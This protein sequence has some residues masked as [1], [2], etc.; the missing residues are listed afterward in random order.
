MEKKVLAYVALFCLAVM[1]FYYLG[2]GV[3]YYFIYQPYAR[4]W[5]E[6]KS[7]LYDELTRSL[8]NP[9][10]LIW[11]ISPLA[12]LPFEIGLALLRAFTLVVVVYALFSLTPAKE[13]YARLWAFI[14]GLVNLHLFDLIFRGQIDAIALLGLLLALQGKSWAT[15]G[16]AYTLLAIKPPN[17]IPLIIYFFW[18]EWKE[19]GFRAAAKTLAIPAAVLAASLLLHGLWPLRWLESYRATSPME[20]W[21]TTLWRTTDML[22]LN[23]IIAAA[24]ALAA[25]AL[26]VWLWKYTDNREEQIALIIITTFVATPYAL[27]YHY[28]F[29][30]VAVFPILMCWKLRVGIA[31]YVLTFL[32]VIRLF[33]GP[34]QSYIDISF[35]L[36]TFVAF[37]FYLVRKKFKLVNS[38]ISV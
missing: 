33:I 18:L 37:A 9:P 30:L 24:L 20:A 7:N 36:A 13:G 12:V 25:I 17:T 22:N 28:V 35:V 3:D 6:G 5:L 21:K 15:K 29:V 32:P 27:S 2:N 10:W 1:A 8:Y 14:L 19:Q 26:A 31:L 23:P 4:L 34:E 16:I 11:L 38:G